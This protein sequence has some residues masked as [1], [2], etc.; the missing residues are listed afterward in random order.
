MKTLNQFL[1]ESSR[2]SVDKKKY[3]WGKMVTVHDG[4]SRTFPLH[5][6]HQRAIGNLAD[7]ESTSFKDETGA[8]VTA[9]RK[10]SQVHL[11]HK[12]GGNPVA[13]A[14]SHFTEELSEGIREIP[15]AHRKKKDVDHYRVLNNGKDVTRHDTYDDANEYAKQ[16]RRKLKKD[17]YRTGNVTVHAYVKEDV[18]LSESNDECP[19]CERE[20]E[21]DRYCSR[22]DHYVDKD[23]GTH[24]H[25][26]HE[27]T[28][29]TDA[30]THQEMRKQKIMH[31][32]KHVAT[33]HTY[34][35]RAGG[36]ISSA[37]NPKGESAN[38]KYKI[39]HSDNKRQIVSKIKK[40][41]DAHT[42]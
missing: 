15:L 8:I 19:K 23:G 40:Y 24:E 26:V 18:E 34:R 35:G 41:H 3:S 10:D 7:G 33:V 4:K 2:V 13:V 27:S 16:Y 38:W 39:D 11:N 14:H 25:A 37:Y 1:N 21:S 30:G 12:R 36:W 5:P 9:H 6:E 31:K 22:C 42:D 32:G 29:I 20:L 17:G 28:E